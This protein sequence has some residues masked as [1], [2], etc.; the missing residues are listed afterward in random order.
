MPLFPA[1]ACGAW[2]PAA[3]PSSPRRLDKTASG[4]DRP[5][6]RVL[7]HSA[8][9]RAIQE[10]LR[11]AAALRPH[12]KNTISMLTPP[13]RESQKSGRGAVWRC[14]DGQPQVAPNSVGFY[15]IH[16]A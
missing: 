14:V 3:P 12:E 15:K 13:D 7:L 4:F 10:P 8:P 5:G 2:Q 9:G 6:G 16:L 1:A 11:V